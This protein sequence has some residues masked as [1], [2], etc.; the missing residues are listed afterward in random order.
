MIR[1]R[2]L[3]ILFW[4]II[5]AAII[6]PGTITTAALAGSTFGLDLIWAL[7]FSTIACIVLQESAALIR[8]GSGMSL[9]EALAYRSSTKKGFHIK[10]L[11]GSAV[12]FGCAAYQTGNILGSA[13]GFSLIH[14]LPNWI[15][16]SSI[17]LGC[18]LMLW[19]GN[20]RLIAHLLAVVVAIMG[21]SFVTLAWRQSFAI[22]EIIVASFV[23]RF[24]DESALLVVSLVGTTIVPYNLFLASGISQSQ[25]LKE[26]RFGM[27]TAVLLGGIISI[28]VLV[29][30]T[31]VMGDFSFQAV[32][33]A[34]SHE[35][36]D[37]AGMMVGIGLFAAGFS[38]CLT[39]SLAAAV[40][41]QTT[42]ARSSSWHYKSTE[43]RLV[44]GS[45][46]AVGFWFWPGRYTTYCWNCF[47]SG[48]ERHFATHRGHFFGS[49]DE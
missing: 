32:A 42:F 27:T 40:T 20:Y 39:A 7:A 22:S 44:W 31:A 33:A 48:P 26:M 35:L 23:P 1:K 45:V 41:A 16:T 3:S 43:Y 11:V 13:A 2:F 19:F 37:W 6:G 29:S 14:N 28:A 12:I 38:S 46:L 17:V 21:I 4:S 10:I 36:G 25:D 30:G 49:R 18:A 24:P 34:M 15:I 5:S 8:I 9:G 47:C